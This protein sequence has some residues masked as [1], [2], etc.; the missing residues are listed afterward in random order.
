MHM[1]RYCTRMCMDDTE[2][3]HIC[4][5]IVHGGKN[6]YGIGIVT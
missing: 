6:E 1:Y 4:F 5:F 2:R 3:E